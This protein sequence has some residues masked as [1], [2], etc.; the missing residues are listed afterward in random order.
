MLY[1]HGHVSVV[2]T[3]P[4]PIAAA[5]ASAI[6]ITAL[7]NAEPAATTAADADYETAFK[8]LQRDAE[9][10]LEEKVNELMKN[11]DTVGSSGTK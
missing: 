11:I 2:I 1:I 5:A 10:R 4:R 3:T 8:K 7:N 9:E 6:I